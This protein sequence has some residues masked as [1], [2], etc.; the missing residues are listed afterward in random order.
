MC[1][2]MLE[3]PTKFSNPSLNLL[4]LS[5]HSLCSFCVEA[6]IP[7]KSPC[8]GC[9]SRNESTT[10]EVIVY[11]NI[12]YKISRKREKKVNGHGFLYPSQR[13]TDSQAN[14]PPHISIIKSCMETKDGLI[15]FQVLDELI[16]NREEAQTQHCI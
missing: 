5:C 1:Y 10:S 8:K 7:V 4:L 9:I 6:N 14:T 15:A 13:L 12:Q 3:H 16:N 2:W 11:L